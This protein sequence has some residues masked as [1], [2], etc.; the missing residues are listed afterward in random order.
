M[1][2]L[3]LS[4]YSYIKDWIEIHISLFYILIIKWLLELSKNESSIILILKADV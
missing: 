3:S 1:Y 2:S 4:A